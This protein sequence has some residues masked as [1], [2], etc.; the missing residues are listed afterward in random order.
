MLPSL[1]DLS[2]DQISK[3]RAHFMSRIHEENGHWIWEGNLAQG[4]RKDYPRFCLNGRKLLLSSNVDGS[5]RKM[6]LM[7]YGDGI[8]EDQVS[9]TCNRRLCVHPDHLNAHS[10]YGARY[11]RKRDTA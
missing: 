8:D 5:A 9:V 10:E 7:L 6:A 4:K 11:Y 2:G 3:L 1:S